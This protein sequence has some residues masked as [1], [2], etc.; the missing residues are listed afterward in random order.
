MLMIHLCMKLTKLFVSP[1]RLNQCYEAKILCSELCKCCGCKNYE[2]SFERKSLQLMNLAEA[3][4]YR[5]QQQSAASKLIYGPD[6]VSHAIEIRDEVLIVSSSTLLTLQQAK[7]PVPL[8]SNDRFPCSFI[9]ADVVDAACQCLMATV[10]DSEKV[11]M[12]YAGIEKALILEFGRC[13][14]QIIDS[15][16]KMKT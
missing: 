1:H 14:T 13:L 8:L 12:D 9:S 6:Y 2:D 4:E 16:N 11:N 15:A 3:A 7:L 5:S 10:E